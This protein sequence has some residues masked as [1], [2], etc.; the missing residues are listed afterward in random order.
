MSPRAS[1]VPPPAGRKPRRAAG[2]IALSGLLCA[3]ARADEPRESERPRMQEESVLIGTLRRTA[4]F[5]LTR[6]ASVVERDEL[7]ARPPRTTAEVLNDEEGVFLQRPTYSGGSPVLRGLGGQQVLILLDGI[8]LNTT[9][10]LPGVNN[11]LTLTDPHAV[12]SVEVQRG[13][14]AVVHGS[15]GLGGVIQVRTRAP[16]PIAGSDIELNAGAK[17]VYTS[18]DQGGLGNLSAGGRWGR[19]ALH[20]AFSLHR[21]GDVTGGSDAPLQPM[22]GFNEG[23]LSV[24]SGVDLGR[25]SLVLM[26]QGTRQYD[27]VRT[28][29][30]QRDDLRLTTENARDLTYLRYNG[31]FEPGG[32]TLG[33]VAT[34]SFQRQREVRDRRTLALDSLLRDDSAVN[35]LGLS[36]LAQA[37][38]G[39]GGQVIAG[40]EGTFE[41]VTSQQGRGPL[42]AG[43]ASLVGLDTGRGRFP[44]GSAAHAVAAY[45][46]DDIDVERLVR[47]TAGQAGRLRALVGARVGG[48]FL[49]IGR[50]ERLVSVLGGGALRPERTEANLVYAGSAHLRFEPWQGFALSAGFQSGVRPPNL[51]DTARLGEDAEGF[52]LP[53]SA[54]LRPEVAYGGE[55]AVRAVYR[56]LEA[57]LSYGYTRINS[58]MTTATAR[59]VSAEVA[60][61][62]AEG[63]PRRVLQRQN[64]DT[65]EIHGI[66]ASARLRLFAGLS[67]M[68][69]FNYVYGQVQHQQGGL[70]A[71]EPL[72][73]TPPLNGVAALQLR[74][75]RSIFSF[76]EVSLRWASAQRDL[77]AQDLADARV[78]PSG[79]VSC[80]GTPGFAVLALRGAARLSRSIYVTGAVENMTNTTHRYHGS[81][82]DGPGI[83]GVLSL[84]ATY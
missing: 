66:E 79:V 4:L 69:N 28:D 23:G 33:I 36:T 74:R 62:L 24:G 3:Q 16:V 78:C 20:S 65:G 51:A 30:S 32:R 1:R 63:C 59:D 54:P 6:A 50:D 71:R 49:L 29:L 15:D 31:N 17:A 46:Q 64:A 19:F 14:G 67:L 5:D 83:G 43:P 73:R 70:V 60:C 38:A 61:L 39:R 26:Y 34:A 25:G 8:R 37:D 57:A 40:V 56:K 7:R 35:V 47:G 41:W 55:V 72:P 80:P 2:L 68:A 22:T 21:V 81:G 48:N 45:V 84:E 53:Q 42:S 75:P 10:T 58:I 12:D 82:V 27:A 76:A 77:A 44:R 11:A 52:Y 18:Y 9:L 13:A